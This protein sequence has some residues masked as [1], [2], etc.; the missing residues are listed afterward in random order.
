MKIGSPTKK[1]SIRKIVRT[2]IA[3]LVE[4]GVMRNASSKEF[5]TR[6]T[7]SGTFLPVRIRNWRQS[8]ATNLYR[9][10]EHI[11]IQSGA[12]TSFFPPFDEGVMCT[13]CSEHFGTRIPCAR[14]LLSMRTRPQ[15]CHEH[16]LPFQ[17]HSVIRTPIQVKRKLSPQHSERQNLCACVS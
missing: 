8:D 9:C 10:S 7:R 1:M 17:A 6:N 13:A 2:T 12:K 4:D 16:L 15:R 3:V 14:P 5:G 11:Q